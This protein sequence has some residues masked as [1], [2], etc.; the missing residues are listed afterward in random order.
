MHAD[1]DLE[2]AVS[3]LQSLIRGRAIQDAMYEEREQHSD[4]IAEVKSTH[5]LWASVQTMRNRQRDAVLEALRERAKL[6]DQV[7]IICVLFKTEVHGRI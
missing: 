4:L 5:A 1:E 7:C 6:D 2:S 3:L